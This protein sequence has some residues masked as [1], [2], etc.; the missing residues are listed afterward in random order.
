MHDIEP[1]TE[2]PNDPTE[3]FANDTGLPRSLIG[4]P[5]RQAVRT[6]QGN[7]YQA[8]CSIDA[9]LRLTGYKVIFL[10]GAEDFDIITDEKAIAVQVEKNSDTISLGTAKAHQAL[11]NF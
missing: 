6:I 5:K 7:I 2:L 9:W 10:E 1:E 4:D 3:G 8:W 11:E